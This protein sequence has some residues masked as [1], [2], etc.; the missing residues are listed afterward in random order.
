MTLL[1]CNTN[2]DP[3]TLPWGRFFFNCDAFRVEKVEYEDS[4]Q[5]VQTP[6]IKVFDKESLTLKNQTLPHLGSK[7]IETVPIINYENFKLQLLLKK[8]WKF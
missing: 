6:K 8:C 1:L 7:K 2:E 3:L 5:E 4:A